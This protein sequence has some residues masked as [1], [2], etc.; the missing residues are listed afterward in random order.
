MLVETRLIPPNG[1]LSSF[2]W[3]RHSTFL[4]TLSVYRL[5]IYIYIYVYSR[6]GPDIKKRP[7]IWPLQP[8]CWISGWIQDIWPNIRP[9][10]WSFFQ[11]GW[12]GYQI[13]AGYTAT[14]E[15]PAAGHI[16]QIPNTE[17]DIQSD[18]GYLT[19]WISSQI[20]YIKK[21]WRIPM[22]TRDGPNTN[23]FITGIR[24]DIKISI[25]LWSNIRSTS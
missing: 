22:K 6:D 4:P 7:D 2:D 5:Y 1:S 11:I 15:Q 10:M 8:F 9:C 19:D 14:A 20:L 17:F 24:P 12:T 21:D 13:E 16:R 25:R 23:S 3:L 18:I